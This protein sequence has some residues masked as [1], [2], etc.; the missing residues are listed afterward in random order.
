MT[1]TH[2]KARQPKED[3][4]ALGYSVLPMCRCQ[5]ALKLFKRLLNI[6]D[7]LFKLLDMRPLSKYIQYHH[8]TMRI[9]LSSKL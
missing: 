9:S 7:K 1:A 6:Q 8:L 4:A 2:N 3:S 5:A